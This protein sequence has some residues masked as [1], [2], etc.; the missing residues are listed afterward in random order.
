MPFG[1]QN[2][3]FGV[4][5]IPFRTYIAVTAVTIIPGGILNV[6]LGVLGRDAATGGTT[7]YQLVLLG[8]G[9]IATATVTILV[10]RKARAKMREYGMK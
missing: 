9:L 6:Y 7:V 2:C 3:L 5:K 10:A 4:T 1:V 8:I